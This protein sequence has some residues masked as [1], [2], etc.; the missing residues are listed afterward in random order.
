MT[1]IA[2][3][4]LQPSLVRIRNIHFANIKGTSS[5]P[6]AIDLRCSKQFPCLG[7]TI[8]NVDLKFGA[9]PSTARCS[10]IK[11]IYSG[12]MNPPACR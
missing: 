8:R 5:T 11:P 2:F 6:L 4:C 12:L 3:A 7:V 1:K 9:A 10:N